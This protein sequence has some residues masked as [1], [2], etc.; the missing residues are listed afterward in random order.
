LG[1][2][3]GVSLNTLCSLVGG[4]T[5]TS[6]VKIIAE[7]NYNQTFTYAQVNGDFVTYDPV[8]GAE[9][10]HSQP[11]MPVVAYYF[12]DASIGSSDGGPLR[13][14]I[15]GPEGLVTDS[16]YWVKWVVRVEV[17]DEAIPE[18]PSLL[19]LPLFIFATLVATFGLKACRRRTRVQTSFAD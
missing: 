2:Y 4:L 10:S 11:L 9:V 1:N 8:T 19:V 16:V 17:F 18:F 5:N 12:N 6:V 15:V 13:L 3:T 7:D 14:A